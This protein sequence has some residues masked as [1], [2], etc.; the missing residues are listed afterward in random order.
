MATAPGAA[1]PLS[2]RFRGARFLGARRPSVGFTLIE[3]LVVIAIIS[4][5]VALL[6]PAVQA[7]REA[8][9]RMQ[10]GN[11]LKQIGIALFNYVDVH[12][13]LPPGNVSM[14][15]CCATPSNVV[16]SVSI[17]PYLER[18][19]VFDMY[20]PRFMLEDPEHARLRTQHISI[21]KCPSD[22][23]AGKLLVPDGGP[24]GNQQWATSSYR[25]MSGVSWYASGGHAYR[26]HWDSADILDP[27]CP[28]HYRGALHW[29]GRV[30]DQPNEYGCESFSNVT[31][32]LS[33]TLLVGEYT[34]RTNP[35]RT[36]F[37][38]YGYTSFAL[39]CMTPESRALMP[40]FDK[41]VSQG[42]AG[43]CKRAFASLHAGG[44]VQFVKC[45]G[46]VAVL[47]QT[48]DRSAY[49]AMS[50]IAGGETIVQLDP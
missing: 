44:I 42:D 4:V 41:C 27:N 49:W 25:G 39:S 11:N 32:G 38:A 5:L 48:I 24:H 13:R 3:V 19:A 34:T 31:D 37:W 15:V 9:R 2:L 35:R 14:G 17:L 22:F 47:S 40:D 43:P 26:R 12:R 10:C 30:N 46:S 28:R 21:F 7:A 8:A 20:D 36:T 6:L 1:E 16:W 33:S 45:D 29:V 23:Q 50:T 18:S